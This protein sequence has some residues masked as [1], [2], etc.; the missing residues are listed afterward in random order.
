MSITD[1]SNLEAARIFQKSLLDW[2]PERS[3]AILQLVEVLAN[4]EKRASIVDPAL[5]LEQTR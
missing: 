1:Q 2:F 4:E 3:D 5:F